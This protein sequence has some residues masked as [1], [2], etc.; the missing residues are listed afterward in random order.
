MV[1]INQSGL[2]IEAGKDYDGYFF[3]KSDKPVILVA[4]FVDK[5]TNATLGSDAIKFAGGNWTMLNF[6][7]TTTVR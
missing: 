2:F 1:T 5:K 6:S 7:F 4:Q 3:A